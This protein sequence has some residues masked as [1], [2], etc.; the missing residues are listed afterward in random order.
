MRAEVDNSNESV[1]KK[2]R[3]AEVAKVPYTVVIGEKEVAGGQVVP[4]IRKDMAVHENG[5][6]Y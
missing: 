3:S 4:R 1:G 6:A 5:R 2:I